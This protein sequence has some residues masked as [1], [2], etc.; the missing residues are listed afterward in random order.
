MLLNEPVTSNR[1]GCDTHETTKSSTVR[2]HN[3]NRA[4]EMPLTH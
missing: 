4:Y 1:E 3:S 2:S